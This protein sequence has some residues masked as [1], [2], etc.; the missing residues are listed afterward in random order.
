MIFLAYAKEKV[1]LESNIQRLSSLLENRSKELREKLKDADSLKKRCDELE[2]EVTM[3]CKEKKELDQCLGLKTSQ[4]LK[5]QS[6][7]STV[8]SDLSTTQSELDFN[9]GEVGRSQEVL[10]FSEQMY[11]DLVRSTA[12]EM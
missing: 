8:Q 6:D 12:T 3:V 4:L 11:N 9:V 2:Q 10:K 7:L 1:N 5:T